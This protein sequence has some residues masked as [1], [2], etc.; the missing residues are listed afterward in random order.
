[1]REIKRIVSIILLIGF[2]AGASEVVWAKVL[3]QSSDQL[4]VPETKHW[5]RGDFL[6]FYQSASDPLLLFGYPISDE[7]V[8]PETG[9]QT[10][11]FQRAR[12]DLAASPAGPKVELAFLGVKLHDDNA[13]LA[14]ISTDSATCRYFKETDKRVCYAFLQFYDG[15]NG[16]V[17]FGNPI[18]DVE[19]RDGRY[20]QYFERARME[21]RPEAPV[22]QH[23]ALTDLGRIDYDRRGLRLNKDGDWAPTTATSIQVNAFVSQALIP[24][25]SQQTLYIIVQDQGFAPISGAMLNLKI[26]F[27]DRA[28]PKS[29]TALATDQDG[30]STYVFKI[31]NLPLKQIVKIEVDAS[32]LDL[33]ATTSTWFRVW[34]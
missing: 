33:K 1:M 9:L 5:I 12:M 13:P 34:Y 14:P 26:Y 31:D 3:P 17:F 28:E 16:K 19:I 4:Y 32:Y 29:Y 30:I 8:D 27:P 6:R 25:W 21:W 11:Y 10:Q 22:E 2:L 18:S 20:V 15:Q 7:F 23:V 24:A